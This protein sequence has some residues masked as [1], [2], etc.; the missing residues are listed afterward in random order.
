[1][2]ASQDIE[3]DQVAPP[4]Q[5]RNAARA[6]ASIAKD[7]EDCAMLLSM[8]GLSAEDGFGKTPTRKGEAA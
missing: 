8:L 6:V 1:V 7:A 2:A 3:F 5:R 4:E